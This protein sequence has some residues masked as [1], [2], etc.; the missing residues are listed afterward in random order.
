MVCNGLGGW[1]GV[2]RYLVPVITN[3]LICL[4]FLP[5]FRG[6]FILSHFALPGGSSAVV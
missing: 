6:H 5:F 2:G 4:P 1:L 3:K